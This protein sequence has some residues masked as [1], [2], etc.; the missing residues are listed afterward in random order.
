LS[1]F[2]KSLF[3]NVGVKAAAMLYVEY[4]PDAECKWR[5]SIWYNSNLKLIN[6][7]LRP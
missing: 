4:F 6:D 5:V 3:I 2:W 7:Q 1:Q